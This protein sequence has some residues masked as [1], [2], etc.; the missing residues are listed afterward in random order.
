MRVQTP[1]FIVLCFIVL[2]PE[3]ARGKQPALQYPIRKNADP[4][5]S[6]RPGS[7]GGCPS[8]IRAAR[9]GR[10]TGRPTGTRALRAE[11]DVT[12]RAVSGQRLLLGEHRL[13]PAA[14]EVVVLVTIGRRA[15]VRTRRAVVWHMS[16]SS[17]ARVCVGGRAWRA[18][19]RTGGAFCS[20]LHECMSSDTES[21][22][23]RNGVADSD[24]CRCE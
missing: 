24:R 15:G 1:I 10:R 2:H 8:A 18:A 16:V 20:V 12:W 13:R 19:P 4:G 17:V 7:E 3:R 22:V 21:C 14:R 9:T 11:G 6:G 23:T 5:G